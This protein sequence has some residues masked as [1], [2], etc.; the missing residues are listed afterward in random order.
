M[1]ELIQKTFT[2]PALF[3]SGLEAIATLVAALIIIR[4]L[5]QL[6]QDAVA[7]KFEGFKYAIELLAS[8]EFMGQVGKFQTFLDKG[9]PFQ[10]KTSLPPLVHWILRTLEIVACLI[11]DKYLD[12]KF[13]FR[14]EGLR[15]ASLAENIRT[16]EEGNNM[17]R[18]EDETRLYPNGRA[19]LHRAE[20]WKAQLQ[21]SK[22]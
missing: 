19:L 12:E 14:I 18:F 17:P 16:I 9:D 11:T 20:K 1:F 8:S 2:D 5:K 21:A 7:H 22:N 13:F 6:R 15:L 3:W 10:F 4:Q